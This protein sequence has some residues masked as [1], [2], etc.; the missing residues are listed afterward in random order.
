MTHPHYV[1]NYIYIQYTILHNFTIHD[2]IQNIHATDNTAGMCHLNSTAASQ[3][4]IHQFK[5]LK[6]YYKAAYDS[7][8]NMYVV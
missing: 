6:R 3:G 4:H 8:L 2:G 7:I 5:N 1:N